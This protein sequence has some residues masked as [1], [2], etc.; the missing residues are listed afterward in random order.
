MPVLGIGND[1]VSIARIKRSLS[2]GK[3]VGKL[4]SKRE[5]AYCLKY[6]DP[7][8]HFAGRFA[9]KEAIVKALGTGVG[10]RVNWLDMEI[11][12][13]SSGQP[14]VLFSDKLQ[15]E[16]A[17]TQILISISHCEEYASAVALWMAGD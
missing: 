4:F 10:E 8:P 15:K 5:E 3:I 13:E 2:R 9:A 7:Y 11:L 14:R 6:K 16:L 12:N 17:G 1:I